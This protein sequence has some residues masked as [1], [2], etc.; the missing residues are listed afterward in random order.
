MRAK[1]DTM[2]KE[3][4]LRH[5]VRAF[6]L[7][8]RARAELQAAGAKHADMRAHTAL[9]AIFAAGNRLNATIEGERAIRKRSFLA[10][11]PRPKA[12]RRGKS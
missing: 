11:I 3:E 6:L 12:P 8:R 2:L 10:L 1:P 7:I 5:L 4:R 9:G